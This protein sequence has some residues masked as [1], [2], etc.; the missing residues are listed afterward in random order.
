M[1]Q[2]YQHCSPPQVIFNPAAAC[3]APRSGASLKDEA[4][5]GGAGSHDLTF[6]T[7]ICWY[8]KEEAVLTASSKQSRLSCH[9]V[10]SCSTVS[11]MG[12]GWGGA[13]VCV[14]VCIRIIGKW[15]GD[16]AFARDAFSTD[17]EKDHQMES[18]KH[19]NLSTRGSMKWSVPLGMADTASQQAE[20]S[21]E[22]FSCAAPEKHDFY[23]T[24]TVDC[25]WWEPWMQA[26]KTS[27]GASL[28]MILI[29]RMSPERGWTE[30]HAS[31][32]HFRFST[33]ETCTLMYL[34][35]G[36]VLLFHCGHSWLLV[37]GLQG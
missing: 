19:R 5:Q 13:F 4:D 27:Q 26:E 23:G 14:C 36:S 21:G 22:P 16:R 29:G 32:K 2:I 24:R 6:R 3:Q 31:I 35:A 37:W 11:Q 20:G 17:N 15:W 8:Q 25:V 34:N 33:L 1:K 7:S 9:H 12:G 18:S 10:F 30:S 28:E